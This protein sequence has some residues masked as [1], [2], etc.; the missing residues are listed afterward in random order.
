MF[1]FLVSND[2]ESSFYYSKS[3]SSLFINNNQRVYRPRAKLSHSDSSS[4]CLPAFDQTNHTKPTDDFIKKLPKHP[5]CTSKWV[6]V[7]S[8]GQ[9]IYNTEFLNKQ[10]IS[11]SNCEY[12]SISWNKDDFKFKESKFKEITNGSYLDNNSEFFHLKCRS[13]SRGEYKTYFAR[14][15]NKQK[16]DEK[17]SSQKPINVILLGLDSVS[18]EDWL[19]NLPKSSDFLLN[20]M[21][22]RVLTRYNIMGDGTPAALI[23]LLTSKH[24]NELPDTLKTSKN[25]THVDKAYPFI[26][27]K[28]KEILGYKTLFGEDWPHVG[29][30]QYRMIGMSKPPVDHYMRYLII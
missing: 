16:D 13:N 5:L 3:N 27:Y 6:N 12:S 7:D 15:F 20:K 8:Q 2:S 9:L 24:E 23:P 19:S 21:K 25:P 28:F 18:R 14:I 22:S 4:N 17:V 26:W 29:T 1:L 10:K 11:I 30:F